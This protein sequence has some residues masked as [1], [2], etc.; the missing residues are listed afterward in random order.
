MTTTTHHAVWPDQV[1]LPGQTAAHPGPVDMTMM[2][3]MHHAFRRDLT[4]FV[5]AAQRTPAGDRITWQAL[6]R[7]WALFAQALHHHHAGED[8]GLW[9]V[10]M[11]R[12][13]DAG[14]AVLRAMED[15]HDEIDP[16]LEAC[17]A[18]FE[19]L[20]YH[21]DVDTRAALAERL[22]AARES[23]GRHLRHEETEAIAIIQQVLTG[24]EWEEIDEKHFKA[25]L[26][27]V[28]LVALAPWA[29]HHVPG[30][31]RRDLF[32]RTGRAHHL[33]WLATKAGF[34]RRERLAFRYVD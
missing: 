32:G 15:E 17:A 16:M 12:T 10:L 1:R 11:E 23:L 7:R 4:A 26:R 27:P 24:Q 28:D 8:A 21:A 6:G 19:R 22:A 5:T 18:G 14:R 30:P 20:A 25:G 29:L 13:D 33:L 2:Y 3:V 9:P 31:I 34:E